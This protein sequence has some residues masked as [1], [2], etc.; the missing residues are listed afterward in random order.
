MV[1]DLDLVRDIWFI[2]DP[3]NPVARESAQSLQA[4]RIQNQEDER[5]KRRSRQLAVRKRD[6]IVELSGTD[7][8]PRWLEHYTRNLHKSNWSR[9][10][11]YRENYM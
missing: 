6:R 3:A 5:R 4:R 8:V 11:G 9:T 7:A 2:L 10:V 1:K